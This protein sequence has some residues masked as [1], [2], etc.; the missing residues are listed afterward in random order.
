[1]AFDG[2]PMIDFW[3]K[4]Y[5]RR[6]L[7][8]LGTILCG[9]GALGLSLLQPKVYRAST[10][11][12]VSESKMSDRGTPNGN[13]LFYELLHSYE[14]FIDNDTLLQ[15]VVEHFQLNRP[16]HN[17]TVGKFKQKGLLEVKLSKNTR[18]LEVSVEFP[19]PK[20]AADM[21][22]Y[23]AENAVAFNEEMTT[24][25]LNRTRGSLKQ[26]LE[27]A[28][29]SVQ[30]SGNAL[31]EFNRSSSVE[32]IQESVWNLLQRMSESESRL[33]EFQTDMAKAAAQ[34]DFL[35]TSLGHQ[36]DDAK[37]HQPPVDFNNEDDGRVT[38]GAASE[39]RQL[40]GSLSKQIQRQALQSHAD[41]TGLKA[42][43]AAVQH[44]L[45]GDKNQLAVLV[46][47]KASAEANLD[48]L[49]QQYSLAKEN[50]ATLNK[51]YQDAF[52]RVSARS[53]DLKVISPAVIPER[54]FKPRIW[55]N[56][57]LALVL[58]ALSSSMLAIIF[59]KGESWK[60]PTSHDAH[61]ADEERIKEVK[62]SATGFS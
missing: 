4:L 29:L 12:L 57:F 34:H 13:Y 2:D 39:N 36:S 19:D 3:S 21:T 6:R 38:D 37:N 59:H 16:P 22:N 33:T 25:D 62:R 18:L 20:L 55:L 32:E 44:S 60:T 61:G 5:R 58:G 15:K 30:E 48:R 24:N 27:Q 40:G 46:K 14:T 49:T 51:A 35:V 8:A 31:S 47:A 54:P 28:A 42:G 11:L 53:T 56:T 23:F 45:Q 43:I 10:Y 9:A 41:M 26:Q 50:F 17:L 52:V 1:M 7:I